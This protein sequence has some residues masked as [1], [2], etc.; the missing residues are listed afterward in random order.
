MVWSSGSASRKAL[1]R[2]DIGAGRSTTVLW[3]LLAAAIVIAV[4]GLFFYLRPG[5]DGHPGSSVAVTRPIS[6]PDQTD[7][8]P[9]PATEL[10]PST[11]TPPQPKNA[12]PAPA[13]RSKPAASANRPV[14]PVPVERTP[15]PPPRRPPPA[16]KKAARPSASE[17]PSLPILTSDLKLQAISWAPAAGDRLAVI[18]GNIVREGATLEGYVIVQIDREEVAVRKGAD[19]WRLVFDLK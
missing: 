16:E 18:N 10:P 8:A 3:A 17:T 12:G 7:L 15:A 13:P 4:G 1:R 5:P 19:Q 6:K 2:W 9:K 14:P 11:A